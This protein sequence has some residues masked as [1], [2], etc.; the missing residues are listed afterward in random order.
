MKIRPIHGT[1]INFEE[2]IFLK[3][4]FKTRYLSDYY[5]L[6]SSSGLKNTTLLSIQATIGE[7]IER[8]TLSNN[9]NNY[10]VDAF[11]LINGD[12]T[13]INL[14]EFLLNLELDSLK[15]S[16]PRYSDTTGAATHIYS[17]KAIEG[18]IYEFVERQSLIMAWLTRKPGLKISDKN[19]EKY[20]TDQSLSDYIFYIQDISLWKEFKV[21]F[22][23][24]INVKEE[25]FVVGCSS[26]KNFY[27]A[28]DSAMEEIIVLARA[29]KGFKN[30]FPKNNASKE[31]VVG[32]EYIKNDYA[33]NYYSLSLNEFIKSYEFIFKN[34]TLLNRHNNKY[35][36]EEKLCIE[37]IK[38]LNLDLYCTMIPSENNSLFKTIKIFSPHAFP[39][40]DTSRLNPFNYKI[41]KDF[42]IKSFPNINKSIPFP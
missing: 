14:K 26:N 23:I 39:H 5:S 24:G 4:K 12:I 13:S 30:V 16:F 15:N 28:I 31:S 27:S 29:F 18:G 1:P 9:R 35:F 3:T 38:S 2:N 6:D 10:K 42:S 11:N 36:E 20:L 32:N 7:Y 19:I 25:L 17:K 34:E 37:D 33:R 41:T 40:M 21:I 8:D 22:I